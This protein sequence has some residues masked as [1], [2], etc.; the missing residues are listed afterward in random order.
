MPKFNVLYL[1]EKYNTGQ[2]DNRIVILYDEEKYYYYGTRS[3][4]NYDYEYIEYSGVYNDSNT[5]VSFLKYTNDFFRNKINSELH[6]IEIGEDEYDNLTFNAIYKKFNSYTE[7]FAY[8]N[9]RE[10]EN[11]INEKLELIKSCK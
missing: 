10:T 3:R 8:E 9:I 2:T 1:V 7:I 6:F 5:L 11:S 4:G